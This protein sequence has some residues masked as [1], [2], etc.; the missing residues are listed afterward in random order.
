MLSAAAVAPAIAGMLIGQRLRRRI[1]E[2]LFRRVFFVALGV[3]GAGIVA[4]SLLAL[5][6][7]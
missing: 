2:A 3:L 4:R 1:P 6:S 7:R 5:V